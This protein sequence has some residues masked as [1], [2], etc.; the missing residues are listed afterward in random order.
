[1]IMD[2]LREKTLSEIVSTHNGA[3]AVFEKYHLDYCCNGDEILHEAIARAEVALD[4]LLVELEIE[5]TN[6]YKL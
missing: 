6:E 1:M 2:Q 5:I 4:D 3:A